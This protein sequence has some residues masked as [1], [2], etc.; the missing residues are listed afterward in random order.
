MPD[1]ATSP[2]IDDFALAS[3]LACVDVGDS[4][5]AAA[6]FTEHA[7]YLR[8]AHQSGIITSGFTRLEGAAAIESYLSQRGR[9]VRGH[10]FFAIQR[11]G[12]TELAFGVGDN[13]DDGNPTVLFF[14]FAVL[15]ESGLIDKYVSAGIP[16]EK[17][18]YDALELPLKPLNLVPTLLAAS[19]PRS[20]TM[21]RL[22][23]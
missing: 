7:L 22:D 9:P 13:I 20:E 14:S 17:A 4:A 21:I 6:H 16:L 3:Y 11:D 10:E 2:S 23:D 19:G 12:A 5:G 1:T 18:A 8:P 15:D